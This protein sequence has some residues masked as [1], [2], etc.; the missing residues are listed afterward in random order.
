M[1]GCPHTS[2]TLNVKDGEHFFLQNVNKIQPDQK[3]LCRTT[4]MEYLLQ[5]NFIL[6]SYSNGEINIMPLKLIAFQTTDLFLGDIF[7]ITSKW[8]LHF[9]LSRDNLPINTT[10][11]LLDLVNGTASL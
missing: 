4:H 8:P 9:S 5:N 2:C 11:F 6:L 10:S 7:H 3:L 1:D